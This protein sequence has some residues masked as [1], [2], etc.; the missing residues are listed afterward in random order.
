MFFWVSARNNHYLPS[1]KRK[2][3]GQKGAADNK[4]KMGGNARVKNYA[5]PTFS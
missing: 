1:A 4:N 2:Q 5:A 3:A